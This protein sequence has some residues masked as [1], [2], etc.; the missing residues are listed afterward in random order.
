MN[1]LKIDQLQS[2][3]LLLKLFLI[4]RQIKVPFH[5]IPIAE[6]SHEKTLKRDIYDI[7]SDA[8]SWVDPFVL[9]CH[10][11][12]DDYLPVVNISSLFVSL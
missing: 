5:D 8:V 6:Q 7:T 11:V 9:I 10:K 1:I 3:E 2:A 12:A 4:T